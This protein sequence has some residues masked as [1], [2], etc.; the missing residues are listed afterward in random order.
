MTRR[1]AL[2]SLAAALAA[3]ALLGVPARADPP[4]VRVDY[5]AAEG[6]PGEEVF[7]DEIRR[8]TSLARVAAP[9]EDALL[10]RARIVRRGGASSGQ[11][12]LGVG[13]DR[14]TRE[15]QS[16][17]CDDVV[18]AL[19]LITALTLDPRAFAVPV[20]PPGPPPPPPLP[21]PPGPAPPLP[22]P[23]ELAP[24]AILPEPL[25]VFATFTPAPQAPRSRPWVLGAQVTGAFA[26]TPRPLVGGGIFAERA[27][28]GRAGAALRLAVELAGTGGLDAGPAGAWFVRGAARVEG[29]ALAV[30]PA[31]WVSL[32]PCV[33]AE[34]GVLHGQGIPSP[35]VPRVQAATVPW[36]GGGILPRA[37]FEVGSVVLVAQGGPMFP[38]VRRTFA[39]DG[40][41]YVIYALPAVTWTAALGGGFHFP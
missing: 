24:P 3:G 29:C 38:L 37:A 11:L 36:L 40:P 20:A 41:S 25:P 22:L 21:A 6:C 14:I 26:V 32:L 13:R 31:P 39:F 23:A 17:R 34:G 27:F 15:V 2:P 9:G 5:H 28:E 8:R 30:R 12:V 19:A 4:P 10:V 35:S 7:L 1:S 33:G 18:S 16:E